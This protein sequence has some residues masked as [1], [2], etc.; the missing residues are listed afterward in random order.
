MFDSYSNY[1]KLES[2]RSIKLSIDAN[3]Q[4]IIATNEQLAAYGIEAVEKMT[5]SINDEKDAVQ[6]M[7]ENVSNVS[8]EIRELSDTL[9]ETNII[10]AWGFANISISLK[11]METTLQGVLEAVEDTDKAWAYAQYD[12]CLQ[13]IRKG[14]HKEAIDRIGYAIN[15][16]GGTHIGEKENYQFHSLL[17]SLYRGAINNPD[18]KLLD[19]KKAE[20]EFIAAARYAEHDHKKEAAEAY[21]NAGI[22]ALAQG[23]PDTALSYVNKAIR[24]DPS[25]MEAHFQQGKILCHFNKTGEAFEGP[26]RKAIAYHPLYAEKAGLDND[27]KKYEKELNSLLVDVKEENKKQAEDIKVN[28]K[29]A[30]SLIKNIKLQDQEIKNSTAKILKAAQ[31]LIDSGDQQLHT[32]TFFGVIESKNIY[33]ES[34]HKLRFFSDN[35][36]DDISQKI[37]EQTSGINSAQD[38]HELKRN[39]LFETIT[40]RL[41]FIISILIALEIFSNMEFGP[42]INPNNPITFYIVEIFW[43]LFWGIPAFF[44]SIILLH[45]PPPEKMIKMFL[46]KVPRKVKESKD[47]VKKMTEDRKLLQEIQ[48][49]INENQLADQCFSTR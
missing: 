26:I 39:Q 8:Y 12:K 16:L 17:G 48:K 29:E 27:I 44:I 2:D 23:N 37:N 11:N 25:L 21:L 46:R 5:E 3:T 4:K 1:K 38:K 32:D 49:N 45:M 7:S 10:F 40:N 28:V 18:P 47:K 33:K 14:L 41:A 35:L 22:S 30:F 34:G 19:E 31:E 24:L 42:E 20:V 6:Q 9:N 15:G 43:V 13:N 36:V